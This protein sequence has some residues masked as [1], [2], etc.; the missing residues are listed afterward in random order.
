LVGAHDRLRTN[1]FAIVFRTP[2]VRRREMAAQAQA[3]E[4]L[5]YIGMSEM[6]DRIA[7][8]LSY[9]DQRRVE[10]ARALMSEPGVL[11]L[12]EPAAGMNPTETEVLGTLVQR[13]RNDGIT[14]ALIEHDMKLV[15]SLCD[16]ILVLDRGSLIA[17]GTPSEVQ[18]NE[19][20]MA[21]YLGTQV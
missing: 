12:D 19:V 16:R 5:E 9:G 10:I 20:V 3:A 13:I 17:E 4:L 2:G 7:G 21:A 18:R 1:P 14:V 15:M 8:T 11:L 6:G